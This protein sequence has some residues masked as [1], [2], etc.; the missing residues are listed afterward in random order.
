MF[1]FT[2]ELQNE[3]TPESVHMQVRRTIYMAVCASRYIMSLVESP[4]R[5]PPSLTHCWQPGGGGHAHRQHRGKAPHPPLPSPRPTLS[6][7]TPAQRRDRRP[8][9]P[10][11]QAARAA[12]ARCVC[13]SMYQ[14]NTHT[15]THIT[16][17][18]DHPIPQ[19]HPH[20][21]DDAAFFSQFKALLL[22]EEHADAAFVV[23]A[24]R[25]QLPAHKAVLTARCMRAGLPACTPLFLFL[26][27][28]TPPPFSPNKKKNT[29]RSD[30][31]RALFR[32]GGMR[33]SEEGVVTVESASVPTVKRML[34][35]VYT[36]RVEGE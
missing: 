25:E 9:P 29:P 21:T 20:A 32:K 36:N 6:I 12:H 30:Y 18:P 28:P 35:W 33:E 27:P 1:S 11:A 31:F 34:E 15:H 19:S 16:D 5:L 23:G 26:S 10:L 24:G 4:V 14:S 8:P 3:D 7:H 22:E 17:T 2:E 13:L